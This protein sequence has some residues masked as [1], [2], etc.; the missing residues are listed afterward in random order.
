KRG[1]IR[2]KTVL[3]KLI[4]SSITIGSGGSAGREGPIVQ[5]GG[6]IGSSVARWLNLN[7]E[8]VKTLVGAGVAAGIASAFN[9]PIAGAFFALE[10]ILGDFALNTF[11]TIII[12]SVSAT[13]TSRYLLELLQDTPAVFSPVIVDT[14]K[15]YSLSHIYEFGFYIILG[16]IA[17]LTCVLFIKS[18]FYSENF[19]ARLKLPAF[20]KPA[21][22]G[23]MVG[24]IALVVP[25]VIGVGYDTIEGV[26][27]NNT[28]FL[29][30][31]SVS[32][33]LWAD[34][35]IILG[36]KI[37]ATSFTLGSGG[38]GGTIVPSLF[39]GSVLGAVL[40]IAFEAILPGQVHSAN[41]ALVGMAAIIAGTTQAPIMAIML[42]F[43]ATGNYEIILP[44]MIVSIISSLITKYYIDGSLYT[45]KLRAQ[46]INLY[47]GIEKTVM[48]TI[49]A[50]E[51]MKKNLYTFHLTTQFKDILD[52]FLKVQHQVA[53]VVNDQKE[54][55]G[56]LS[57]SHMK[58]VIQ[59]EDMQDLLIA[60]DL[61]IEDT[62]FAYPD[63]TLSYCTELLSEGE[64]DIIPIVASETGMHL[65][66][67]LTRKDILSVY[68]LE[69]MKKN[70]S[71]LKFVSQV[72]EHQ[73]KK[74]LD[75]SSNYRVET[76]PVPESFISQNLITLET[77]KNYN[78]TVLAVQ[79]SDSEEHN[80][81]GPETTFQ[82]GDFLVVVAEN[83]D[84]NHFLAQFS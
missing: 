6:G 74:Y 71:G 24:G 62:P 63:S 54:L 57:L 73:Q 12:A 19:F 22:G 42:F 79:K 70:M 55:I 72:G 5:I 53:F 10:I 83:E 58:T 40:G 31:Y 69:V 35:L 30:Q 26:L 27:S 28:G 36:I 14:V 46:G 39:L 77:R 66:G 34:L 51:I 48:S 38:S 49:T 64:I 33:S 78:V 41:Y 84:M 44:V 25:Q 11:S 80:I 29:N 82:K 16:L 23:L 17:G 13:V 67:Y 52:S 1:V 61:M 18:L 43:E 2:F 59:D 47:E 68:N 20:V 8:H 37:I 76:I 3:G 7:E 60:E 32:G 81:P 56:T 21:I 9:A 75:L 4:A 45:V 50:S 65:V 15:D